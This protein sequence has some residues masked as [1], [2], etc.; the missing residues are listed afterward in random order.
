M[1]LL[2]KIFSKLV[3]EGNRGKSVF[4][5]VIR[6]LFSTERMKSIDKGGS[7]IIRRGEKFAALLPLSGSRCI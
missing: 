2:V 4:E 7:R 5:R 6:C 3:H 1:D